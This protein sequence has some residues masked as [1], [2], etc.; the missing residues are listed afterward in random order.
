LRNA[1]PKNSKILN[2]NFIQC[3]WFFLSFIF[4]LIAFCLIIVL[5]IFF[6]AAYELI[7][8]YNNK[9]YRDNDFDSDI[10]LSDYVANGQGVTNEV[11][12]T[13][14]NNSL[15][16]IVQRNSSLRNN[17]G[18]CDKDFFVYILLFLL[19]MILQPFFLVYKFLQTLMEC[20]KK[21]GCWFF[22]MGNY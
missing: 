10:D 16:V 20:Y 19:G 17:N 12:N 3:L 13:R 1:D 7:K 18:K 8:F 5:Y 22:Y 4:T 2:N 14:M 9:K 15:N 11:N 21:F 6:G